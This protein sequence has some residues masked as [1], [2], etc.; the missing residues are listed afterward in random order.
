VAAMSLSLST[1][2]GQK[3]PQPPMPRPH[4]ISFNVPQST[5]TLPAFMVGKDGELSTGCWMPAT[6]SEAGSADSLQWAE[7]QQKQFEANVQASFKTYLFASGLDASLADSF[8]HSSTTKIDKL[9]V[10]RVDPSTIR[11]NFNNAACTVEQLGWF[12]NNRFVVT[13]AVKAQSLRITSNAAL[14]DEQ[15]AKV[16]LAIDK[17]NAKFQSGFGHLSKAGETFEINATNVYIGGMGTSLVS[18]ECQADFPNPVKANQ[19]VGICNNRFYLKLSPSAVPDRYTLSVTPADGATA[20]FDDKLGEQQIHPVGELRIARA[21]VE[22]AG[23][24]FKIVHLD[25]LTVGASGQ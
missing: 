18:N 5:V 1:G 2:C 25:I 21:M 11:P 20:S 7:E 22:K 13:A 14:S 3:P 8:V 24:D 19:A 23:S 4:W 16:D 12:A 9:S 10:T 17:I 15:K 6:A